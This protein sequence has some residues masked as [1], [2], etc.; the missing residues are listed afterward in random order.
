VGA[1]FVAATFLAWLPLYIHDNFEKGLGES[2][3]IS[4]VWSLASLVGAPCGGVAADWAARQG[5]GGRIIVQSL[6]LIAGA[7]FVYLAG[8]SSHVELLIV[9]LCGAGFCKGIYDANIFASLFDVIPAEDRG[10]AA[11]LM[12]SLGWTGGALAPTV[13]GFASERLGLGA[14]LASTAAIYLVVGLLSLAAARLAVAQ[15]RFIRSEGF[16]GTDDL[17]E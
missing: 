10:T 13:V 3:L 6:A 4:T 2:S 5:A 1:N 14:A 16:S 11:G 9:A 12:N 15:A 7:P 17:H 8:Q